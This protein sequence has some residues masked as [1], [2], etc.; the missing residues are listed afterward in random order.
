MTSPNP[1]TSPIP[2]RTTVWPEC[3]PESVWPFPL[4]SLRISDRRMVFTDTGGHG[5]VLLFVHVGL[6]CL[7]WRDVIGRLSDRYRC[8]T[9][10]VPGS[11]LSGRT[12]RQNQT[13]DSAAQAVGALIDRLDLQDITLVVHDLGGLATLAAVRPRLSRVAAVAAVN[14]FGWKPRGLMLPLALRLFGSA[15]MRELDAF[16][17]LLP[18]SSSSPLGVGRRWS[19]QIKQAWRAGLRDH[20]SRRVPHRLFRDAARNKRIHELADASLI[21]LAGRPLMTVFG[22]YGDYFWFQRQWRRRHPGAH[23]VVVPGGFH[24]PMCDNP[25][26]VAARLHEWHVARVREAGQP[27]T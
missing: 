23:S 16:T 19:R 27:T 24:F 12:S 20:S 14:T 13:L 8:I 6:W 3:L 9:L 21:E 22:R 5:P 10:D 1:G 4:D 2:D 18:W 26:L 11:G 25:D 7:M 15:A 17:G